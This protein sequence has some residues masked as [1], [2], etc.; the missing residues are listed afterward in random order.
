MP[1][2]A[3]TS[4]LGLHIAEIKNA[5]A[6]IMEKDVIRVLWTGGWDSTFRVL[7]SA[8]RQKMK[9]EP[10]YVLDHGRGSTQTE[11]HTMNK[12]RALANDRAGEERIAPVRT[13]ERRALTPSR[14]MTK[15]FHSLRSHAPL[16]TQYEWL[17][18]FVA[19]ENLSGIEL[20]V[21]QDDKAA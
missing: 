1:R 9:V 17:A 12:I 3:L 5:M 2:V 4:L 8:I 11:L 15:A 16:G 7:D 18:A 6:L 21:H 10:F 13:I 20:A 14:Q 19:H